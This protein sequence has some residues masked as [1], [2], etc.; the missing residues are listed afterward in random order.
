MILRHLG[1]REWALFAAS[2]VFIVLQVYLDLRIPEYM[3]QITLALENGTSTDAILDCGIGMLA[4]ALL[5]M[6]VSLTAGYLIA[7]VASSLSRKLRLMMLDQVQRF[8]PEDVD[9]FSIASLI[10]RS[11]NDISQVQQFVG[12]A[13]QVTVKSPIMAVWAIMKISGSAWEWTFA[14]AIAVVVLTSVILFVIWR[15][16]KYYKRIQ[17]LN[18]AV[19]RETR[20]SITGIRVVR[21]YNAEE[22]QAGKFDIASD[23][24]LI[25]NMSVLK[26]MFPMF[27]MTSVVTNFLTLSIYWIGAGLIMATGNVDSQMTLF[28]DMIVFSCPP[29]PRPTTTHRLR[30]YS[31]RTPSRS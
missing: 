5:S 17:I 31:H 10:T 6:V 1:K 15:S 7:D 4:C 27:T 22:F 3:S 19:N 11:T 26:I 24:L 23:D 12:R 21:A 8:S 30:R 18:D 16:M 9:R 14:T 20:E 28:A 2:I 25:N 13:L 29:L